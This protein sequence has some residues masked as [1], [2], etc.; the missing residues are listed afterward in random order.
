[1]TYATAGDL[2]K[3]S[4]HSAVLDNWQN[5]AVWAYLANMPATWPIVLYWH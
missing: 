5:K 4:E 1:M 2:L 3:L